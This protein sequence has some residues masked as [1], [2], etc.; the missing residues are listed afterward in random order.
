MLEPSLLVQDTWNPVDI[1]V[2]NNVMAVLTRHHAS[3]SYRK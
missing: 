3:I 2:R 1:G